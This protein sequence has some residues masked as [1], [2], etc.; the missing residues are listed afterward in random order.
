MRLRPRASRSAT[1]HRAYYMPALVVAVMS[2]CGPRPGAMDNVQER[3]DD[4]PHVL[5]GVSIDRLDRLSARIEDGELGGVHSLLVLRSGELVFERYFDRWSADRL[6]EMQSISKSVVSLAVGIALERGEI[7]SLDERV[8]DFF[9]DRPIQNLDDRKRAITIGDV[10]RMSTGVDYYE[11]SRGSPHWEL[12]RRRRGWAQYWLDRPMRAAPATSWNY[13]SGGVITLSSVFERATGM[14]VD[15]YAARHIF[16]PL[17]IDAYRWERNRDGEPHAGGGLHLRPRDL[18]KIGL[19]VG[20]GGEWD[21]AQIVPAEWVER[22]T[23]TKFRFAPEAAPIAG[24]AYLW[25]VLEP[26][27]KV[28][29]VSPIIAGTGLGGQYLFVVPDRDLVVVVTGWS[30]DEEGATAPMRFLYDDILPAVR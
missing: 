28:P 27:A 23:R 6:H 20:A 10:L 25:W 8:V 3:T 13:D 1:R 2:S 18:A 12:N 19:L 7:R 14:H 5:A 30:D 29:E 21:G 15:D 11:G 24:Y 16:R 9:P 26:D 22:S 4:T 17:G